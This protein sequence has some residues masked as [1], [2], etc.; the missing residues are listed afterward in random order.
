MANTSP[1]SLR[2]KTLAALLSAEKGKQT[3]PANLELGSAQR[4]SNSKSSEVSTD[5]QRKSD[6][7]SAANWRS[8]VNKPS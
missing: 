5:L 2:R 3:K 4:H 6:D 7:I 8:P 1:S